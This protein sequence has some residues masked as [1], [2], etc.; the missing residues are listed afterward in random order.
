MSFDWKQLVRSVS[1][2]LGAAL[3]GP[4]GGVA[5]KYMA[6]KWLGKADATEDEVA[7]AVIG[8]SPEQMVELR[9]LDLEFKKYLK[10]LGIR[11]FE[12][13]IQ[14]RQGARQLFNK[15]IW[16]QIV[17][18]AIFISGYFVTLY[19]VLSGLAVSDLDQG[20]KAV[21]F[22][23]I[24]VITG[25][26]PRIMSFWFGSSSGSKEKTQAMAAK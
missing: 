8:A 23:L 19:F 26:V 11:E 7:D 17:L 10:E 21:A 12:L 24:G 22:T 18:S 5:A 6:D 4:M 14:D 13:E 9:R 15:N 1:P 3:G 25:E 20:L 2:A 16:P